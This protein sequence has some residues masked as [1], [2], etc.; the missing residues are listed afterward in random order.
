MNW[1]HIFINRKNNTQNSLVEILKV[2]S[3]PTTILISPDGKIIA[4]NKPINELNKILKS[5]L[6]PIE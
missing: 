2:R 4:R 3:F 5:H 1:E 6:N